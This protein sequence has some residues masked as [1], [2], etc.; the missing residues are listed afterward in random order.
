MLE[1]NH[2]RRLQ[3]GDPHP[4]NIRLLADNRVAMIDFGMLSAAP[5][6]RAA[7]VTMIGEMVKTYEDRFDAGTFAVAMLGFLDMEMH[8]ALQIVA[9]QQSNDYITAVD[10]FVAEYVRLQ[11]GESLTQHYLLDRQMARL[12]THVMNRGNKLGI[13]ISKENIMLQRSMNMYLSI[14]RGI[15]EK[16]DGKIHFGLLH[17][18]MKRVYDD[19]LE[20]GFTYQ[21]LPEMSNER[22]YEVTVNWLTS[23]AENDRNLFGLIM[24]GSLA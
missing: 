3:N 2:L 19:A 21:P 22:T 7:F 13:R 23:I 20:Q 15:G 17:G 18:I 11:A 1:R 6:D 5:R 4:G 9:R 14:V 16:H 10:T 12:F 8:D 24:K